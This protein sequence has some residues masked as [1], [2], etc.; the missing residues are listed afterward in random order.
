MK[1]KYYTIRDIAELTGYNRST[2]TRWINRNKIKHA[3]MHNNALLFDAQVFEQFQKSHNKREKGH[4]SDVQRMRDRIAEL[5]QENKR[6]NAKVEDYADKFYKLAD[7]A[8]HLNL[9]DKPELSQPK[10]EEHKQAIGV[11]DVEQKK[12]WWQKLLKKG[13]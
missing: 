1:D 7:Q 10:E 11:E 13:N 8:Q 3:S 12:H 2:V 6:L 9:A 5:E 4:K